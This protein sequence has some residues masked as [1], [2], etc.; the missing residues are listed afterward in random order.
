MPTSG[1]SRSS[2][3]SVVVSNL[4]PAVTQ[5]DILE[6]FGD[7]GSIKSYQNINSTTAMVNFS[8]TQE[9]AAAVQT[10]NNRLLDGQPMQ[11]TLIPA[12]AAAATQSKRVSQAFRRVFSRGQ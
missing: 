3:Y 2:G 8:H 5:S 9:A 10:Y 4:N 7:V 1:S 12:P 11:V 6:L